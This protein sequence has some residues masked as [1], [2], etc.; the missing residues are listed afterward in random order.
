MSWVGLFSLGGCFLLWTL[1]ESPR[2]LVQERERHKAAQSLCLLRKTHLIEAELDEIEKEE[3]SIT[4]ERVSIF[5]IFISRRFRWP[6][7]TSI[8]LNA[9]QQ[10]S[11]INTV[12]IK[13]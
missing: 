11:G 2:W 1:P 7:V 4:T 3:A 13:E 12:R 8:V 10:L 5:T 6:L 9:V